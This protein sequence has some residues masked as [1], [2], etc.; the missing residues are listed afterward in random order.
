MLL[1]PRLR[2]VYVMQS[3]NHFAGLVAQFGEGQEEYLEIAVENQ[4]IK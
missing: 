1:F 3:K 2:Y 4:T